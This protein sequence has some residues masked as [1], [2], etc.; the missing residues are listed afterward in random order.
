VVE[1]LHPLAGDRELVNGLPDLGRL[2]GGLS[3]P[4]GPGLGDPG[5][6]RTRLFESVRRLLERAC[7]RHPIVL[8]LDDMHWADRASLALLH[9]VVRGLPAQPLLIL[10][11]YRDDE[12]SPT[13]T[14][15]LTDFRRA[16][17]L[18]GLPLG[19]LPD[20]AVAALAADL[21]GGDAP[22][23][24]L[25]MLAGR[26]GGVP[27]FVTAL[28][29]SLTERGA[30]R[31]ENG[32]WELAAGADEAVPEVVAELLRARIER[33][34]VEAREVLDLLAVCGTTAEH[35]LLR[36][37][38]PEDRLL[39]GLNTLRAARVVSEEVANTRVA[40]RTAHPLEVAYGLLPLVVRRRRHAEVAGALRD[41]SPKRAGMLA[42]HLRLADDEV[43]TAD[44]LEVLRE[45]AE[46]ALERKAGDEALVHLRAARDLAARLSRA[47]L[48]PELL[49][50][51]AKAHELSAD[52]AQT[53]AAWVA[54]AESRS[55]GPERAER[56]ARASIVE[57]EAGRLAQYEQLLGQAEAQLVG[58]PPGPAHARLLSGRAWVA[59]RYGNTRELSA[60][61][62]ELDRLYE[63]SGLP[64]ARRSALIA[65]CEVGIAAGR[66][67]EAR[68]QLA[69]GLELAATLGDEVGEAARRPAFF[70]ELH[71]GDLAAARA[72]A[73]EALRLARRVGVPT[74]ERA[75][76]I[77]LALAAFFGGEWDDALR[78]ADAV[79]ELGLR[80][81]MPRGAAVGLVVRG[82]V[83]VRRGLLD[84]ACA[85]TA[86][87]RATLGAHISGDRHLL[88]LVELVEAA[89]ALGR[90]DPDTAARIAAESQALGNGIALPMIQSV[91]AEAHLALGRS[92]AALT[93]A[94]ELSAL[95][96]G[97]PYPGA[98]AAWVRGRA[99]QDPGLLSRAVDEL[100]VLG[101]RY[102][103][104]VAALD[105]AELTGSL[106][107]DDCVGALERMGAGP[108][109]DR[110]RRLARRL[111]HRPAPPRP[112]GG[113]L[114]VREQEV[115]RLVAD[116]LSNAQIAARLYLSTR[117]VT[118]HL[119]N[120]YRR[121]EV[122][123][124]TE[125][126]RY[127]LQQ[128]PRNT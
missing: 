42:Q 103:A 45:A 21:L 90:G 34:P 63:Q 109:L 73:E 81:G 12:A 33:L 102:E 87:G 76:R 2:F 128:L 52:R 91:R 100:G 115:A 37:M 79:I 64:E 49:D 24:L 18:V 19:G 119:H 22:I 7:E 51:I 28:V 93:V 121:L 99:H 108:Q 83:E 23:E 26:S 11:T 53:V 35:A 10:L 98:L 6:E 50:R 112:A 5:L 67:A 101:F 66:Y 56:L 27:L 71:W 69:V 59:L 47:D 123:S 25:E 48:V 122:G 68:E 20:P 4:V 77:A 54:A 126:T 125:L 106:P 105:L 117:T 8:L 58:I 74:L 118:T 116:G 107:G 80:L 40:Y 61:I 86:E 120:I 85:S 3:L 41:E 1:A 31:R 92:D 84:Q 29:D 39:S 78:R 44:T 30:L 32:G 97:A 96:P 89:A 57:W 43:D 9:Y 113:P 70:L 75:P 38:L 13:L 16:G 127:V 72:T 124:R 111:G 55:E 14:G 110:A 62:E 65:R 17:A 60:W 46:E 82:L 88:G 36:R 94:E 104:A 114:S 15:L 95:G